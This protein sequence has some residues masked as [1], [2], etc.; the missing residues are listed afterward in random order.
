MAVLITLTTITHGL[1]Y[2]Y[3]EY[4]LH[5][6]RGL[7]QIEINNGIFDAL[8]FLPTVGIT[9]FCP[10]TETLKWVYLSLAF[11]SCVSI[12][13]NELFYPPLEKRE[14][15]AHAGLYVLHPLILYAFYISWERNFFT[16]NISYWMLQLGYFGL[17][18][19]AL[20]YHII[21]WNYIFERKEPEV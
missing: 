14:R 7:S 4:I 15:V 2:F 19:K 5:K 3:D 9:I 13:K 6:R 10:F 8:L 20:T 18:S 1:L 21:Y 12:I 11:L 17:G 16:T